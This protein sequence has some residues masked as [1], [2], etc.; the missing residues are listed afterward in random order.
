MPQP[1]TQRI[2]IAGGGIG[3]LALA[4]ALA[5]QGRASLVLEARSEFGPAGAGIQIGPNGVRVLEA[6][7]AAAPLRPHVG[8]P[9]AIHVHRGTTGARITALP[10]GTWIAD[11]HGA[12]YWVAHRADL[13]AA[14]K[15]VADGHSL[16]EIR[17]G[18]EI[19]RV[20]D[21]G[22]AIEVEAEGGVSEAGAALIGA[23]GLW[24]AVR[25]AVAPGIAPEFA[26][27]SAS[28]VVLPRETAGRLAENAVGL[29][30]SPKAHVVHYPLRGGREIAAVVIAQESWQSRVW[31]AEADT[32]QLAVHLAP[33]DK[34]LSQVLLAAKGWRRW[35][36]N[37][38]AELPTFARGRAALIGDAAH[39]MFPYLAQGGVLALEDAVVL[40]RLLGDKDVPVQAALAQFAQTR[41]ARARRV[42]DASRRN[43]WIYH[44]AGPMALA[45]DAV[46]A[47]A[48]E[49]LMAGLD[50]LYGWRP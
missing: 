42:Q 10:L 4:I 49:R 5:Q 40:A 25:Q 35:S 48:P 43:G 44:L 30:L 31:D 33:F 28:R 37:R 27:A 17:T 13:H 1:A 45:R 12:P 20:R 18:F 32:Q 6:L 39:P 19:R 15:G 47:A 41:A 34:G 8:V 38:M 23:D 29:W 21:T 16:I 11:R 9:D 14:L 46:M 36:L 7:G 22:S 3:G 24:S 26:G 2:L 50:W